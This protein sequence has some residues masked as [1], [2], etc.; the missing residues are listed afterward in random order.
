M[1]TIFELISLNQNYLSIFFI[2]FLCASWVT[3]IIFNRAQIRREINKEELIKQDL[4]QKEA[5][6][7]QLFLEMEEGRR[8]MI[9]DLEKVT[10]TSQELM[11]NIE[12]NPEFQSIYKKKSDEVTNNDKND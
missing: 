11:Q 8:K 1:K 10:T 3:T 4:R 12:N 2:I 5:N 6:V 7:R 9:E